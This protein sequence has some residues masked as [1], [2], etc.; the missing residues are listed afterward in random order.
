MTESDF[1]NVSRTLL[2]AI[3]KFYEKEENIKA[4]EIW[5]AERQKLQLNNK[6]LLM[7]NSFDE[8]KDVANTWA[9][10][11]PYL[12]NGGNKT[13]TACEVNSRTPFFV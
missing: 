5:Q 10:K 12:K 2:N 4:F 11:S 7:N 3:R 6:K 13:K 8:Q 9:T 1:N